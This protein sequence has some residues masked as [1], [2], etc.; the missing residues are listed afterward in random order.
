MDNRLGR[1]CPHG[2]RFK[3]LGGFRGAHGFG[4][5]AALER[6]ASGAPDAEPVVRGPSCAA[7]DFDVAGVT[8]PGLPY[9][10]VGHNQR[11]AWGFTN[12]GPTV[13]DVYI[14]TFNPDGQYLTPEGWKAPEHRSEVIHV[15]GKPDVMVD[16]ALTRHGPIITELIPGETRKMALR[17][18]LYDGT[19]QSIF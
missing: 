12:I 10:I 17:W 2:D 1:R 16:V 4:Q 11:I 6:Y 14:E 9:V 18:T 15:K 7:A 13:E 8:L 19:A 3:Q 5:A